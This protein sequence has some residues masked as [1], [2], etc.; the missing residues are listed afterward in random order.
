M[1]PGRARRAYATIAAQKLTP[2]GQ[3]GGIF[4]SDLSC[5][6]EARPPSTYRART[7]R[8][9]G[10]VA[11]LTIPAAE[12]A[13]IT[14]MGPHHDV[15]R[16]YGSLGSYVAEHAIGIDG[17]LR[18]FYVAGAHD[19]ADESLW[20]TEIGWPIS[21]LD[22]IHEQAPSAVTGSG[23]LSEL[24]PSYHATTQDEGR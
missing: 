14:H 9:S 7:I 16:A 17:P 13:V 22:Q 8:P 23:H 21:H 5:T 15:D 24:H 12:L 4:A 20:R 2:T 11:A 18:E 6:N 3:A 1:V 10:R 19:T